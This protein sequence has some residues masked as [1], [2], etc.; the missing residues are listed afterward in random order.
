MWTWGDNS[1]GQLGDGPTSEGVTGGSISD[2]Y[3]HRS[4]TYTGTGDLNYTAFPVQVKTAK[5]TPLVNVVSASAN[6][7]YNVA[8]D[9]NGD[10]YFGVV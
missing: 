3:I 7:D 1:K 4:F 9:A 5:D 10:V 6:K 8:A 2:D